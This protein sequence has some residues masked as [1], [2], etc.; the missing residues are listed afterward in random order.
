[1]ELRVE[2]LLSEGKLRVT[3]PRRL[4][5]QLLAQSEAALSQFELE[6]ELE[7]H[8]D[9]VTIYRTL[10][11]FEEAGI[12]HRISDSDGVAKFALCLE[13]CSKGS[14]HS[15][16]HAHFHC[17][18]CGNTFCLNS[19]RVQMPSLPSGYKATETTLIVSGLCNHCQRDK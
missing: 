16:N 8:V 3:Q 5:M 10:K 2:S 12:V 17:T 13:E 1:M 7:G 6:R 9:R 14:S 19:V 18:A 15:H 4:I 11:A